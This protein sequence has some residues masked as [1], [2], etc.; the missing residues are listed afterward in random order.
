MPLDTHID[1]REGKG[2]VTIQH[3]P[4]WMWAW[5]IRGQ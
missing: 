4:W 3:A 1:D 5:E 2:T